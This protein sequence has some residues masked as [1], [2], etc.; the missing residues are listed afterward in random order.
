MSPHGTDPRAAERLGRL[1]ERTS[2]T[3]ALSIPVLPEPTRGEVTVAYLLFRIADTLEDATDWPA[4]RQ[5]DELEHLA[6][7]MREPGEGAAQR[8]ARSWVEDPP[9]RDEAYLELLAESPAVIA[10]FQAL[11]PRARELVRRHTLRTVD[12]MAAFVRRTGDG[13]PLQIESLA[14][15]RA[16][17]YAVAGIVGEMLTELFLLGR[18]GLRLIAGSL[19][20]RAQRFGEAL[21]LV[22]ILKDSE[23]D[24]REGRRYLPPGVDVRAVFLMAREDLVAAGGYVLSLQRAAAPRGLVA[25]TALPVLLAWATLDRV[26]RQGSGS[27]LT[28]AEVAAIVRQLDHALEHDRPAVPGTLAP[29]SL[30][31]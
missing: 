1:L 14:D 17:C 5:L 12:R 18:P 6:A 15:L 25:F 22:N 31:T 29:E 28:R 23:A 26:E 4:S 20:R 13:R 2:R 27:K 24:V 7:L 8:L 10:A 30:E 19:R 9:L 3:F 11:R 21:Q 16:Y